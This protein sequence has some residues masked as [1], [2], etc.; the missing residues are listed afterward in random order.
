MGDEKTE[1]EDLKRALAEVF[2]LA[3]GKRVLFWVLSEC[4]IYRSAYAGEMAAATNFELGRQD[5]GRRIIDK[6]DEIDPRFYP[7]LLM[8]IA[9][10]KAM[11]RA[12][13]ERDERGKENDDEIDA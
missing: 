11:D 3:S 10:L 5:V 13:T 8:D 12:A 2:K 7:Q 4:S 1:P 6:L 9:E